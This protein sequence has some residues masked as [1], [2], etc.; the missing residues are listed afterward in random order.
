MVVI[1]EFVHADAQGRLRHRALVCKQHIVPEGIRI[2]VAFFVAS[3]T[4]FFHS[5]E[6]K[7]D[8]LH[9]ELVVHD[10][11]PLVSLQPFPR[12]CIILG[13]DDRLRI[14]LLDR[15]AETLPEPVVKL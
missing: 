7:G 5:R 11:I 12:V 4:V 1:G 10:G 3:V 13:K 6:E 2:A 9:K 8:R 14:G 15:L